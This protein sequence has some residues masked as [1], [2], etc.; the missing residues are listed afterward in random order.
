[1]NWYKLAQETVNPLNGR[2]N[3]SA[4]NYIYKLIHDLTKGIYS[5]QSWEAVNAIWKR[6]DDNNIEN[7]LTDTQYYKDEQGLP[8]S[9]V[10]RFEIPFVNNKGKPTILHG[11]LTAHGAGSVKYPLDKYDITVMMG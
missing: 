8:S 10:W 1:M 3:Q 6:L 5:D 7:Y 9:K 11:I 4:K 2:S